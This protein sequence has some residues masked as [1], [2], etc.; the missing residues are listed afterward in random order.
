MRPVY[1]NHPSQQNRDHKKA[2][3]KPTAGTKQKR[4]VYFV[5]FVGFFV[6]F[7]ANDR[8]DSY[9]SAVKFIERDGE[10]RFGI[11]SLGFC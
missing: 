5:I 3:K 7:V 2:Q 8:S 10:I 11:G 4:Q 6:P 9:R 1:Y